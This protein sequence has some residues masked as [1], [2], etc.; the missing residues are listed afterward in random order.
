MR[1]GDA[2][3]RLKRLAELQSLRGAD[4]L[5]GDDTTGQRQQLLELDGGGR[6]HADEVFHARR[7]GDRINTGRMRQ[8]LD[9]VHQRRRDILRDHIARVQ[10]RLWRQERLEGVLAGIPGVRLEQAVGAPLR[11]AR[12]LRQRNR[13]EVERERQR[14]PVEVAAAQ[15]IAVLGEDEGVIGDGVQLVIEDART[16]AK[17]IAR[18]AE[19]LGRAT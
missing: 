4:Q 1:A 12:H 14:L 3:A 11:E 8:H 13:Q 7:G 15:H 19:H 5:D 16:V 2:F 6:A 18:R 9:L 17:G 10:A